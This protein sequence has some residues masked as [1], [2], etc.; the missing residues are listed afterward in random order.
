[1]TWPENQVCGY[2]RCPTANRTRRRA[3]KPPRFWLSVQWLALPLAE[4]CYGY[5]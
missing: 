3:L 4:G 1:M 5:C 2:C